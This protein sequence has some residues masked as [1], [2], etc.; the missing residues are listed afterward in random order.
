MGCTLHVVPEIHSGPKM[1]GR[2][3]EVLWVPEQSS[4]QGIVS[5]DCQTSL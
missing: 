1:G 5:W 2:G 4:R 3:D